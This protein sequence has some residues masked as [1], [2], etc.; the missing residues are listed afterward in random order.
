MPRL[1]PLPPP[2]PFEKSRY[3]RPTTGGTA[4][5]R[6]AGWPALPQPSSSTSVPPWKPDN[7]VST[8]LRAQWRVNPANQAYPLSPTTVSPSYVPEVFARAGREDGF[9]R[10][11][12][13]HRE[14]PA[15]ST[16][17]LAGLYRFDNRLWEVVEASETFIPLA[18]D[19]SELYERLGI[20]VVP[21]R[22]VSAANGKTLLATERIDG[23]I[24][25]PGILAAAIKMHSQ[26]LFAMLMP[27]LCM[28]NKKFAEGIGVLPDG[29][30]VMG[31]I[32]Q[33][34]GR[35]REPDTAAE[36]F[37]EQIDDMLALFG[38]PSGADPSLAEVLRN[39]THEDQIASLQGLLDLQRAA[40]SADEVHLP[41][42]TILGSRVQKLCNLLPAASR[43]SPAE[44]KILTSG[45][46]SNHP[47]LA[48]VRTALANGT[49]SGKQ[50]IDLIRKAFPMALLYTEHGPGSTQYRATGPLRAP[51]SYAI[52]KTY[53]TQNLSRAVMW[54]Q[55]RTTEAR[56]VE[57][58]IVYGAPAHLLSK[59][60]L[61]DQQPAKVKV[62]ILPQDRLNV[63]CTHSSSSE[64]FWTNYRLAADIEVPVTVDDIAPSVFV[65]PETVADWIVPDASDIVYPQGKPTSDILIFP[66]AN[67]PSKLLGIPFTHAAHAPYTRTQKTALADLLQAYAH[68]REIARA[69]IIALEANQ[70]VWLERVSDEQDNEK[71]QLMPADVAE[72]ANPLRA[73]LD[74]VHDKSGLHTYPLGELGVQGDTQFWVGRRIG[75][76][77]SEAHRLALVPLADAIERVDDEGQ[78][79][80]LQA[81]KQ[82]V[83]PPGYREA[84]ERE[85]E[86]LANDPRA[87]E[88][89]TTRDTSD[90]IFQSLQTLLF[91]ETGSVV[92]EIPHTITTNHTVTINRV[93]LH[94][95]VTI[96]TEL[97]RVPGMPLTEVS[98]TRYQLLDPETML[99]DPDRDEIYMRG[100]G[101]GAGR[102]WL[103]GRFGPERIAHVAGGKLDS[104]RVWEPNPH[105]LLQYRDMTLYDTAGIAGSKQL[106]GDKNAFHGYEE[107]VRSTTKIISQLRKNSGKRGKV[108]LFAASY[109]ALVIFETAIELHHG[110]IKVDSI[111]SASGGLDSHLDD[112]HEGDVLPYVYALESYARVAYSHKTP[113]GER[114]QTLSLDQ[115]LAEVQTFALRYERA[116]REGVDP[117]SDEYADLVAEMARLTG[118][119]PAF[120][121]EKN[122]RIMPE[123]FAKNL[124]DDKDISP[125]DGRFASEP[126]QK[127]AYDV[128]VADLM[129]KKDAYSEMLTQRFAE[130]YG[131]KRAQREPYDFLKPLGREWR[132]G[133]FT[134]PDGNYFRPYAPA[135]YAA[136]KKLHGLDSSI[137]F[138][139]SVGGEDLRNSAASIPHVLAQFPPEMA[140][141]IWTLIHHGGHM[142]GYMDDEVMPENFA[143]IGKVLGNDPVAPEPR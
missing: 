8:K 16:G 32:T 61:P 102:G 35:S 122:L 24:N 98:F 1:P 104:R 121:R 94:Y 21:H 137:R 78:R 143:F 135:V 116:L 15:D 7:W 29:S 141:N 10:L 77:P 96:G 88:V 101:P 74:G 82:R 45:V 124:F 76:R 99:P 59:A 92:K 42:L 70:S 72:D 11:E 44:R 37:G 40:L 18:L 125:L 58:R 91:L 65:L 19:A 115:L 51:S 56:H 93:T 53:V 68:K 117:D 54:A 109:G 20:K 105:T 142:A 55:W 107:D 64:I 136:I 62:F 38:N 23:L 14:G 48:Y 31:P 106:H 130:D 63:L 60:M 118:L 3:A 57:N 111:I 86:R 87:R 36:E 114:E 103:E 13:M 126:V 25:A 34:F 12:D 33:I 108:S 139:F 79:Q 81:L 28:G 129:E 132:W 123:A 95:R 69:C 110:G 138:G 49:L 4:L 50:A 73:A 90:P 22:G 89:I 30:M 128:F 75:G 85:C 17:S 6:P 127:N 120:I 83:N 113:L 133:R 66:N 119:K 80:A 47:V 52:N 26:S 100:G 41:L 140:E 97:L 112:F 84:L 27:S 67:M 131:Y 2:S 134:E 5:A 71:W 9:L 46:D 39:I 43:H